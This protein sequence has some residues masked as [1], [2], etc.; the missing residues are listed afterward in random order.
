MTNSGGRLQNKTIV[1]NSTNFTTSYTY[2]RYSR[3]QTQTYPSGF[4]IKNIYT[5]F[6]YL[7]EVR[8]ND[9]NALI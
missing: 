1:I 2:D 7:E 8:R 4:A 5:N 3:M 9:N 6:G